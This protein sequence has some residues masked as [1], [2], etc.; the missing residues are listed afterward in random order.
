[1]W[2]RYQVG[3]KSVKLCD[4]TSKLFVRQQQ[5]ETNTLLCLFQMLFVVTVERWRE[6]I[7]FFKKI[8]AKCSALFPTIHFKM[9][10]E[11][12][13]ILWYSGIRN[14]SV[15]ACRNQV[16]W[17]NICESFK[18]VTGIHKKVHFC[19]LCSSKHIVCVHGDVKCGWKSVK[20]WK[21]LNYQWAI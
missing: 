1:M 12:H 11:L 18:S 8:I 13:S 14:T 6:L 5:Q 16:V 20:M 21:S 7:V 9:Y 2:I 19:I 17:I 3:K 10:M 4:H 15:R